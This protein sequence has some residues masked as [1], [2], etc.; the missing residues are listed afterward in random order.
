MARKSFIR[1]LRFWARKGHVWAGMISAFPILIL[2]V[3]GMLLVFEP[4]LQR[5]EERKAM[6][7][8]PPEAG[9]RIPISDLFDT[10]APH[11]G[12]A[13]I[14]VYIPPKSD[15]HAALIRLT[16]KRFLFVNPYTGEVTKESD[17]VAPITAGIRLLHTSFF[18]GEFGTWIAVIASLALCCLAGTGII[19]FLKRRGNLWK[20]SRIEL[21]KGKNRR[22]YDV[23]AVIGFYS[24]GLLALI[25]LSGALIGLNT[26]WK[27]FILGITNSEFKTSPKLSSPLP[28]MRSWE[29]PEVL[30]N[31]VNMVAPE[32]MVP[33][34]II[35]PEESDAPVTVRYTYP[36][37][38]RPASFGY[39][40]P[41]TGKVL[42]FNHFPEFDSGH[43]I[44][45]LN[46][47]FHTGELFTDAMRWLW[48]IIMAV[49]PVLALTGGLMWYARKAA[50]RRE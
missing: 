1:N 42:A 22:N 13:N 26:P 12:T 35:F 30:L 34:T 50:K 39:V 7:I 31:Q 47:G 28:D 18:L 14:H 4:E 25:A 37:A 45:R 5:F 9:E 23:H 10:V 6:F 11:V 38:S 46:R 24:G 36:W 16:D 43:L 20:Q 17:T 3:T 8:N 41:A 40:H 2:C 44:H 48:F 49:P 21:N 32:G 27:S 29:K 33:T 15:N 19:L